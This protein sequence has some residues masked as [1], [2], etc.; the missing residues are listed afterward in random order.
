MHF[1]GVKKHWK[2]G[3][4]KNKS[5]W[6]RA[7]GRDRR[8]GKWLVAFTAWFCDNKLSVNWLEQCIIR[9]ESNAEIVKLRCHSF[10]SFARCRACWN[11]PGS[12]NAIHCAFLHWLYLPQLPLQVTPDSQ[13]RVQTLIQSFASYCTEVQGRGEGKNTERN[14]G[15]ERKNG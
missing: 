7:G 5:A 3:G 6:H 8:L 2:T 1:F 10:P 15:R 4:V 11:L 12:I 13:I 14:R 9:Q